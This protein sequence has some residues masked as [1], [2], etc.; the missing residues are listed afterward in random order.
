MIGELGES[1]D[2]QS[3]SEEANMFLLKAARL[4]AP[5]LDSDNWAVGYEWVCETLEEHHQ[6]IAVQLKKEKATK[7]LKHKDIGSAVKMLKNLHKKRDGG[8]ASATSTNLSL[9]SFIEGD[10]EQA[11]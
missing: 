7:S 8:I 11:S 2:D 10:I 1:Q 6:D 3:S 9:A 4:I 5:K